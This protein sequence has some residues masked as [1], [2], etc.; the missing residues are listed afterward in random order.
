[1]LEKDYFNVDGIEFEGSACITSGAVNPADAL[2]DLPRGSLFL[3]TNGD[4]WRKTGTLPNAWALIT[5]TG[6]GGASPDLDG[7]SSSSVYLVTQLFD[8]GNSLGQ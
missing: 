4:V 7:G 3:Q 2:I 5:S 1:M 6:G 8:G